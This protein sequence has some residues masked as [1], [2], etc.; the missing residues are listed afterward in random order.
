M[1]KMTAI[2]GLVL[3]SSTVFTAAPAF[4]RDSGHL[5]CAG[6][7]KQTK[8]EIQIIT[9]FQL[10]LMK[11]VPVPIHVPKCFLQFLPATFIKVLTPTV[12]GEKSRRL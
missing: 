2:L 11:P 10:Y 6:Y 5:V 12:I 7:M 9:E 1:K 4:A 3:I 8:Y